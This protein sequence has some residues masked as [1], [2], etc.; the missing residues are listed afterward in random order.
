MKLTLSELRQKYRE[1]KAPNKLDLRE[2]Y[3][4]SLKGEYDLDDMNRM[5]RNHLRDYIE[6]V[7]LYNFC[8][9]RDIPFK[10]LPSPMKPKRRG[11]GIDIHSSSS[12]GVGK[13]EYTTL[14]RNDYER[15]T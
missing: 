7:S 8:I 9:T 5:L 3:L 10:K 12:N 15:Y 13:V 11:K 1:P 2:E 14:N 4:R 6:R